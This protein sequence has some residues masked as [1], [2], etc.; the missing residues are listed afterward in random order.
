MKTA[1]W[2]FVASVV[3]F[4]VTMRLDNQRHFEAL[5]DPDDDSMTTT[6]DNCP[7]VKNSDQQDLDHDGVGDACDNCRYVKNSTQIDRDQDG[8]GTAC[9]P[10]DTKYNDGVMYARG[11]H[12]SAPHRDFDKDGVPNGKD[13]CWRDYN[14]PYVDVKAGEVVQN[15]QLDSDRD[16][17]GDVCDTD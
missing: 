17:L 6:A 12:D 3:I 14:P 10:V 13:N 9:D 5:L 7:N 2:L 1:Q 11:V 8:F 16:G 15:L 4:L